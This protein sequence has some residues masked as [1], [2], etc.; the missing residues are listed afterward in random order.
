MCIT[1]IMVLYTAEDHLAVLSACILTLIAIYLQ[2]DLQQSVQLDILQELGSPDKLQTSL[3]IV[4]ILLGF[5]TTGG[6]SSKTKLTSY[7]RRLKMEKMSFSEKVELHTVACL[8]I[9][10]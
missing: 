6:A 3:D 2:R 4:E 7:L 5:L 1:V 8:L 10:D 9:V